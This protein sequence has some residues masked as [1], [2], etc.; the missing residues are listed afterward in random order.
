MTSKDD[1][2]IPS[3]SLDPFEP[4]ASAKAKSGTGFPLFG[5]LTKKSESKSADEKN[6][7]T[8]MET[9]GSP[10]CCHAV[11]LVPGQELRRSLLD[12][13][14]KKNLKAPFIMM[15]VG[16]AR[17]AKLRM[18]NATAEEPHYVRFDMFCSCLIRNRHLLKQ[19]IWD[20]LENYFLLLY[21]FRYLFI[22]SIIT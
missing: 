12:F 8:F 20:F 2:A 10:L 18:A 13:V 19:L 11:R 6:F 17:S 7:M 9:F 4:E 1:M 15:C 22:V 16:S 5:S 14:S 21:T 3:I